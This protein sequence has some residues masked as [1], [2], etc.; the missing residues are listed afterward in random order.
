[1]ARRGLLWPGEPRD[2]RG[3]PVGRRTPS[4][5]R[6][7]IP[8]TAARSW[9]SARIARSSVG[10]WVRRSDMGYSKDYEY[11]TR[12]NHIAP[13]KFLTPTSTTYGVTQFAACSRPSSRTGADPHDR[14]TRDA[15]RVRRPPRPR[16]RILPERGRVPRPGGPLADARTRLA[17]TAAP[18]SASATTSRWCPGCCSVASAV[19]APQPISARYPLVEADG[20]RVR[21]GAR[22]AS[23]RPPRARLLPDAVPARS[24][25]SRSWR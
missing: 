22:L 5:C 4:R 20:D 7:T 14:R 12:L 25:W 10:R 2:R 6:T 13:P 21:A 18:R 16:D 3:D 23:G 24:S 1:M 15:A 8:A 11:D 17:R 9:S 19:V